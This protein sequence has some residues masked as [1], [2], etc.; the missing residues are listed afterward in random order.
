MEYYRLGG[1]SRRGEPRYRWQHRCYPPRAD[2]QD[3]PDGSLKVRPKGEVIR[4]TL[5][6]LLGTRAA[7]SS[8]S[9]T[10]DSHSSMTNNLVL[11]Y[12]SFLHIL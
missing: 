2:R 4:L 11:V 10:N 1:D 12:L 5:Y 9:T 8:V 3:K 7:G 6:F